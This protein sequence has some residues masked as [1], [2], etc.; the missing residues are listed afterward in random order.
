MSQLA[1]G[2]ELLRG[3][4]GALHYF[5]HI[6]TV[7]GM[8]APHGLDPQ[9]RLQN[10]DQ[11]DL[12]LDLKAGAPEQ[13]G[14]VLLGAAAHP[15]LPFADEICVIN[16]IHMREDLQHLPLNLF[17][18]K[19]DARYPN[20]F[21]LR[22]VTDFLDE[23][24]RVISNF[25]LLN[26]GIKISSLDVDSATAPFLQTP[27]FRLDVTNLHGMGALKSAVVDYLDF[28]SK[29]PAVTE[30]LAQV[31]SLMQALE[32]DPEFEKN[33][34]F[35][36]TIMWATTLLS[37]DLARGA[38]IRL[39]R[40]ATDF[41]LDTHE[42][43]AGNHVRVQKEIWEYVARIFKLFKSIQVGNETLYDRTTFLVT[44]EMSRTPYLNGRDGKDHNPLTTSFLLAGAGV[45]GN[46][47]IGGSRL[48]TRALTKS[49]SLHIARPLDYV[50]GEVLSDALL[51]QPMEK[52]GPHANHIYVENVVAT[53]A[54]ALK[55]PR[56]TGITP[57]RALPGVVKV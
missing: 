11:K 51:A 16:G 33:Q 27:G 37:Q 46:Q 29:A 40:S 4:Q 47:V 7:G 32:F 44:S 24:P 57:A 5:V 52:W 55:H 30:A 23:N 28:S 35:T 39:D 50:T 13:R 42:K 54:R 3:R 6:Q 14:N 20:A 18:T 10:I 41:A 49:N 15:M 8:D 21:A 31:Q 25:P 19:G 36:K 2:R 17:I 26:E 38:V 53:L 56:P 34:N 22:L 9:I 12:F 48:V 43:F 1:F 45:R